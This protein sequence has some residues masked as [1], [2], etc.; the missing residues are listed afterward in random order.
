[1]ASSTFP[2]KM[3]RSTARSV[4]TSRVIASGTGRPSYSSRSTISSTAM[5]R[6]KGIPA[7]ELMKI[8]SLG[9]GTHMAGKLLDEPGIDDTSTFMHGILH[10]ISNSLAKD[11]KRAR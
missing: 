6:I 10:P 9:I 4:G 5:N 7:Q 1:M 2:V 11:R 8:D 3:A